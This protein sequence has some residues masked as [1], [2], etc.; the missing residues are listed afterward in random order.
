MRVLHKWQGA[1]NAILNMLCIAFTML[2][3]HR[4]KSIVCINIITSK[5]NWIRISCTNIC[6]H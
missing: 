4:Q 1:Y 3:V 5:I 2:V 6:I